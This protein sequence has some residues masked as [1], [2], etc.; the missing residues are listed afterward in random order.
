MNTRVLIIGYGSMAYLTFPVAFVYAIGF[1]GDIG[2][3]RSVD[4]GIAAPFGEGLAVNLALLGLFAV[5]HSVMARPGFKRWWTRFV[6]PSV[7]RSTYVLIASVVLFVVFWQWRTMPAVVWDVTSSSGRAAVWAVFWLGWVI[8][9]ASTFMISHFELF[10]LRQAYLA[11]RGKPRIDTGFRTPLL[12][13]L[14]RHPLMVGFLMAFWS[15]PTMTAGHLLFAVATTAYILIAVQLEERDL[16]AS[17]GTPYREY[18]R[19]VPMF[20]P[21]PGFGLRSSADNWRAEVS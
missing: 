11:S 10:G 4:N 17:L 19:R 21:R 7:E 16:A 12:Y 20:V 6:A 1:L 18:R 13:R 5:Q 8:A 9:L 15:A 3:P 14:I 2:V